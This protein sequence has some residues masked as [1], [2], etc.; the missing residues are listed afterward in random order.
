MRGPQRACWQAYERDGG[1]MQRHSQAGDSV[2]VEVVAVNAQLA[3]SFGRRPQRP[4]WQTTPLPISQLAEAIRAAEQQDEAVL[5]IF[6]AHRPASMHGDGMSPSQ[7]HRIGL[8]H[9]S[10][11]LLTSVRRSM[12]NLTNAGV[13]THLRTT[14]MGPYRRPEGLWRLAP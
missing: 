5:A 9:G 2:L 3:L 10:Q 12:T 14:R 13:L 11:W 7:V 6:R 8:E 4:Y 1:G